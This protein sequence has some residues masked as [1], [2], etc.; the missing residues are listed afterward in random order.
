[1]KLF[2]S[3]L[4]IF[5]SAI[6][7]TS[8]LNT[9]LTKMFEKSVTTD[10]IRAGVRAF[11]ATDVRTSSE[12]RLQWL[13]IIENKD[14][15]SMFRI[16]HQDACK[17]TSN[18][19]LLIL[20]KSAI[21]NFKKRQ[22]WRNHWGAVKSVSGKGI[23]V[24]YVTAMTENVTSLRHLEAEN[25]RFGDILQIG[26]FQDGYVNNTY[27]VL[28]S[29]EWAKSFCPTVK[30]VLS[31]DDDIMIVPSRLVTFLTQNNDVSLFGGYSFQ[32]N[33]RGL[34]ENSKWFV[35]FTNYPHF[36]YPEYVAGFALVLS[37]PLIPRLLNASASLPFMFHLDDAYLGI[38]ALAIGVRP[39]FIPGFALYRLETELHKYNYEKYK[40]VIAIHELKGWEK[41][42]LWR[43]LEVD[44]ELTQEREWQPS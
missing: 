27:K 39:K 30:Y 21:Q 34:D 16:N 14:A 15:D 6:A 25:E 28:S 24:F 5:V 31:A 22:I 4:L 33:A 7:I 13:T 35:N 3:T 20:V 40:S 41:V 29:F 23:R 36:Y 43:H 38:C 11:L 19:F 17:E 1:M 8:I 42:N 12:Y 18:L 9:L 26:T 2:L 10:G 44:R 37:S 32:P